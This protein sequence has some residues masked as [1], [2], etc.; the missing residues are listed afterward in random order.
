MW[1]TACLSSVVNCFDILIPEDAVVVA[2]RVLA[3]AEA[4]YPRARIVQ[5]QIAERVFDFLVC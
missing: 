5:I 1:S 3:T 4:D 2:P